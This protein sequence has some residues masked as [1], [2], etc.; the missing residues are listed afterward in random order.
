MQK[1]M[2]K[3]INKKGFT[4]AE[5]LIVIAI[6][7]VLVA[8]AI[9][10]FSSQLQEAKVARDKANMRSVKAAAITKILSDEEM[11]PDEDTWNV[12]AHVDE[13]GDILSVDLVN[14]TVEPST[15]GQIKYTGENSG[16]IKV[17]ITATDLS[18]GGSGGEETD[19]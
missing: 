16:L 19:P 17:Q 1:I 10:I 7:A 12:E 5:L 9:P 15:P 18:T 14:Y 4:L 3:K 6:I 8:V 13:N 2:N 11:D